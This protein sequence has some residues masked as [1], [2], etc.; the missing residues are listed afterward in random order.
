MSENIG[1]NV[2][3]YKVEKFS[4]LEG[5]IRTIIETLG[6]PEKQSKSLTDLLVGETWGMWDKPQ[7]SYNYEGHGIDAK[8]VL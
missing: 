2:H 5:R 4:H 8:L 3:G 7:Y 1:F 6:L